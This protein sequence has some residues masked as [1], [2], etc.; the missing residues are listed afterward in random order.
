MLEH[1]VINALTGKIIKKTNTLN[2]AE[3]IA[4]NQPLPYRIIGR[5]NKKGGEFIEGLN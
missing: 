2:E 3:R 1:Y 4:Q 5:W